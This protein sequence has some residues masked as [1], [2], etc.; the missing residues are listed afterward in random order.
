[1][2]ITDRAAGSSP[3]A[4]TGQNRDREGPI[5]RFPATPRVPVVLASRTLISYVSVWRAAARTLTELGCQAFFVSGIVWAALGSPA[6]WFVLAAVVLGMFLRSGDLEA[7]A[8]FIPGGLYGSVRDT[9][10]SQPAKF[11]ASASLV[12]RL[13]LGPLAAVVA[14]HYAVVVGHAFAGSASAGAAG[15]T[16]P[17]TIA[18]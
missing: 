16:A 2:R 15:D 7:R 10:G 14:G 17:V 12:D 1:M 13:T 3:E 8:L 18:A 9:L 11:A 6:P 4:L 5:A